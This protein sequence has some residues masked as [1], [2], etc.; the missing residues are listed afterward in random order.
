MAP[1]I[2]PI[3]VAEDLLK[4]VKAIYG[5]N[6]IAAGQDTYEAKKRV[7][8]LADKLKREVLGRLE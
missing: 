5:D 4:E 3:A 2:S 7:Q 6:G 8:A 1:Q